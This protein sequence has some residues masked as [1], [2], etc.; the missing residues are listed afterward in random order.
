LVAFNDGGG[1][2]MWLIGG[3]GSS[4]ATNEVWN[5]SDGQTWNFAGTANFPEKAYHTA[6]V[7]S[8]EVWV[9]GGYDAS[10]NPTSEVWSS[11]DGV[12]W[13]PET[14]APGFDP[15]YSHTCLVYDNKIWV[16]G[17]KGTGSTFYADAWYS[18]DGI[19]WNSATTSAAFGARFGHSSVVS[20]GKMWVL[21]G[22]DDHKIIWD[23]AWFSTNGSDWTRAGSVR[24]SF[25]PPTPTSEVARE[26]AGAANYP[27]NGNDYILL[28]GGESYGATDWVYFDDTWFTANGSGWTNIT[29]EAAT[30]F[31]PAR[32]GFGTTIYNNKIWVV[33]GIDN[34][35]WYNDVWYSPKP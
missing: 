12:N 34:S 17:G 24:A 19:V 6:V 33:G 10:W 8:N 5:S 14:L 29:S 28:F 7:F 16:I 20:N 32:A 23:D 35:T 22:Q 9:I 15:R 18:T 11:S 3:W 2:K 27:I 30:N 13:T 21:C 31:S 26:F 1:E 25:I 4:G